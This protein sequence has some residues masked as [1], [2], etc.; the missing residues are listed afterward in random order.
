MS[1]GSGHACAP[2]SCP[3]LEVN[4]RSVGIKICVL[5]PRSLERQPSTGSKGERG[6]PTDTRQAG[7]KK[8]EV[9]RTAAHEPI[10][11]LLT[12]DILGRNVLRLHLGLLLVVHFENEDLR[13]RE[14]GI[15]DF[16]RQVRLKAT[17]RGKSGKDGG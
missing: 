5:P 9:A 1:A 14:S 11:P 3:P 15:V 10:L 12:V 4:R 13:W 17:T 2:K 16:S 6:T 7:T 8:T